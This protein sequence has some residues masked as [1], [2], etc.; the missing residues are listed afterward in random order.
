[1]VGDKVEEYANRNTREV[2]QF[3]DKVKTC[4]WETLRKDHKH[5]EEKMSSCDDSGRMFENIANLNRHMHW[6]CPENNDLN[7]TSKDD[8]DDY[9]QSQKSRLDEQTIIDEGE[10]V[11]FTKLAELT[12]EANEDK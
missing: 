8:G 10:D 3:E 11:A 7:L 1:M 2:R 4:I 5:V 9:K 12:R 6:W